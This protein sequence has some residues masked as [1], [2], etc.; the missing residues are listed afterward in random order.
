MNSP[1]SSNLHRS[2]GAIS[3]L[4]VI[5]VISVVGILAWIAV[6]SVSGPTRAASVSKLESDVTT[7]NHAIKIYLA[8][9]GSLT[10][11]TDPQAVLDKMKT[12]RTSEDAAKFAGF[13]GSMVDPRLSARSTTGAEAA[14]SEKRAIWNSAKLRF[15]IATSGQGVAEF[16]LS[17]A[18]GVVDY[19]TEE[20]DGSVLD[21]ET[22]TGWI[23]PYDDSEAATSRSTPSL[24]ALADPGLTNPQ[25][26][27]GSGSIRTRLSPPTF[28]QPAGSYPLSSYDLSLSLLDPN[29]SCASWIMYSLN[30]SPFARYSAPLTV[31]PE[32][33]VVAYATG[34]SSH[35]YS[36]PATDA[37]YLA[38]P[39]LEL[40]APLI[41]TSSDRFL[42]STAET[43]EVTLTNS[44]LPGVSSMEYQVGSEGWIPY[45][46]PF[47]LSISDYQD[48]VV[49][50]ARTLPLSVDYRTSP[51]SNAIVQGPPAPE[52]LKSPVISPSAPNFIPGSVEKVN[53]TIE[54]PNP[55]GSALEYRV[56]G[57][58]WRSYSASFS[59][60][61]SSYPN[62][63]T[64]E[65]RARST[66][67]A[68]TDSEVASLGIGISR[69]Q[70]KTPVIYSSAPN[71]V[72]GM[73][74]KVSV[75]ITD[76]NSA[77]S[78]LEYRLNNASWRS[79]SGSFT[80]SRYTY[81]NGLTIEARA[82]STS[83]SYAD[84]EVALET[85]GVKSRD[86]KKV[87]VT[88]TSLSSSAGYLNEAMIYVNG[89]AYYLGNSD[90]GP[91]FTVTVDLYVYPQVTNVFDLTID[92]YKRSGS[93]I[94][95][96]PLRGLDTRDGSEFEV[97]ASNASFAG[98]SASSAKIKDLSLNSDI[99]MVFGYEDLIITGEKPD[100]D[101]ND[102]MFKIQA[103]NDFNLLFGGYLFGT[104]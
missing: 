32:T 82:R 30:G 97:I 14:S 102:F 7:I 5:V 52:R 84:S 53:I 93:K 34:D 98:A 65:A 59:V 40:C 31:T 74:E 49:V 67:R 70:L 19:G 104:N 57:G 22:N 29:T 24:V 60:Y 56:A 9:G 99:H 76:L 83:S 42:W 91:G 78:I 72:P 92:T 47:L 16:I 15:D 68:F 38:R 41:A 95:S 8:N 18:K 85:I 89:D 46:A 66:S 27:P 61:R 28:S 37:L 90:M 94:I 50:A 77:N 48:G 21:Y 11:V 10:G 73:V 55:K 101:Y 23:W 33:R 35:Y 13:S 75:K 62:G 86:A 58:S 12:K 4:E 100:Y 2:C 3:L 103:D 45:A 81:P 39:P 44:N 17:D 96:D 6:A 43:V 1:R 25:P 71:F 79:Y 80:V 88:F 64:V 26:T 69:P 36:S 87:A 51:E 63:V 20:R 54:N